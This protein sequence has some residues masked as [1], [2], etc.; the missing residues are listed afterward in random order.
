MIDFNKLQ[1]LNLTIDPFTY[2]ALEYLAEIKGIPVEDYAA[3]FL[4]YDPFV[5]GVA[6]NLFKAW[7][8]NEEDHCTNDDE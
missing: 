5:Y 4:V 6:E 3:H 1:K 7:V 2:K 8:K